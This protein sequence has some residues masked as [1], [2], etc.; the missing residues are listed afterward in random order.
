MEIQKKQNIQKVL[1]VLC[2]TFFS[3]TLVFCLPNINDNFLFFENYN[4][5]FSL[6]QEYNFLV[7]V[8][9]LFVNEFLFIITSILFI[10]YI[11]LGSKNKVLKILSLILIGLLFIIFI[12]HIFIG[13]A[14]ATLNTV[15]T[16]LFPSFSIG[17]FYVSSYLFKITLIGILSIFACF[18]KVIFMIILLAILILLILGNTIK[19]KIKAL[20]IVLVTLLCLVSLSIILLNTLL[21]N[22]HNAINYFLPVAYEV[23]IGPVINELIIRM[24]KFRIITNWIQLIFMLIVI[25]SKYLVVLLSVVFILVI[26]IFN[27]VNAFKSNSK[28]YKIFALI[29]FVL[30][31]FVVVLIFLCNFITIIISIILLFTF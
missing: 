21:I 1:Y 22:A 10:G 27:L 2:L 13:L 12:L 31:S 8:I 9:S 30:L 25:S 17:R 26:L 11:C 14:Q 18:V 6:I 28:G 15:S 20:L 3:L 16:Y 5:G 29:I 7:K 19:T 4:G 24:M 23:P